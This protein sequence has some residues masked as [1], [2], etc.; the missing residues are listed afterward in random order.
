MSYVQRVQLKT[1]ELVS[2][3]ATALALALRAKPVTVLLPW[4]P[5]ELNPN[6]RAHWAVKAR[7]V[8]K[9]RAECGWALKAIALRKVAAARLTL[10]IVFNPPDN[11]RRD[12]DN[13]IAAFKAAQDSI[14]DVTGV[15]DS[16]F[17]TSYIVFRV[18]KS[19]CIAV[20]IGVA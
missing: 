1:A 17:E 11:R 4:P 14:A 3:N 9:Y 19:G 10:D 5:S 16:M 7:A 6:S 18:F 2:E 12:R 13:M 15:D 20:T 8:K